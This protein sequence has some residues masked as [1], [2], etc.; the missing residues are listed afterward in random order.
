MSGITWKG[1]YETNIVALDKEHQRLVE[2]INRLH[3]AIRDKRSEDVMLSIFDALVEYTSQHF[4]HE[5]RLLEEYGYPQ[6]SEQQ[7]EHQLLAQQVLDYR[8][9]LT[10]GTA[11]SATEVMG[12]LRNWLLDHIVKHDK[13]YGPYLE[14]RAG[15]FVS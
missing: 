2:Q 1:V 8:Q 5:E 7:A 12:F 11:V 13:H 10:G 3:Q 4:V 9:H 15:R 14:S 6:L